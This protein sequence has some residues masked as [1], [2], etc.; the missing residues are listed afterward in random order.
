MVGTGCAATNER[1]GIA[2]PF[3]NYRALQ[4][5]GFGI[6]TAA[7]SLRADVDQQLGWKDTDAKDSGA[8]AQHAVADVRPPGH[9]KVRRYF[10]GDGFL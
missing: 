1:C 9:S 6:P 4:G 7:N 8:L 10:S 2:G 5:E 3:E